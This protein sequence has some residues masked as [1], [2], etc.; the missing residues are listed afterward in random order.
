MA[1]PASIA[2]VLVVLLLLLLLLLLVVVVVVEAVVA[3]VLLLDVSFDRNP[4]V[5]MVVKSLALGTLAGGAL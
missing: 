1:V 5:P 4:P 3:G 2:G